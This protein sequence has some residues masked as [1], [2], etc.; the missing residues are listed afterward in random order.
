MRSERLKAIALAL[1]VLVPGALAIVLTKR[2]IEEV[3]PLVFVS[4]QLVIGSWM[5]CIY[6]FVVRRE[7]IAA[8]IPRRIWFYVIWIG[9]SNFAI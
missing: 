8:G 7:R 3:P 9:L 5:I 1:M 2:T 6:T 4:L